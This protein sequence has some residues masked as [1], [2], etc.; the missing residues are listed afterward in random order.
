VSPLLIAIAVIAVTI[1]L[2]LL[3]VGLALELGIVSDSK[4]VLAAD[5]APIVRALVSRL[6]RISSDETVLAIFSNSFLL[7]NNCSVVTDRRLLTYTKTAGNRHVESRDLADLATLE[8]TQ[9]TGD[10]ELAG[11]TMLTHVDLAG[12]TGRI[13]LLRAPDCDR[14]FFDALR[15]AWGRAVGDDQIYTFSDGVAEAIKS[16]RARAIQE[17]PPVWRDQ[18][19]EEML[20]GGRSDC[21]FIRPGQSID[22]IIRADKRRLREAGI[23]RVGLLTELERV[24]SE[25]W[26]LMQMEQ[27]GQSKDLQIQLPWIE[28]SRYQDLVLARHRD[29]ILKPRSEPAAPGD[30]VADSLSRYLVDGGFAVSCSCYMGFQSCPFDICGDPGCTGVNLGDVDIVLR[31]QDTGESLCFGGLLLHLI[32]DHC[33]FEGPDTPYRLDPIALA[34]FLGLATCRGTIS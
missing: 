23:S 25:G 24:V 26:R 13:M 34:N 20:P 6:A 5:L 32:Q 7:R 31:R 29:R 9:P 1:V 19:Y 14:A 27:Y 11:T 2:L 30:N 15:Q 16:K 22:E 18:L 3:A 17:L 4:T 28:P 8:L 12:E 21:G 33:F 10:K